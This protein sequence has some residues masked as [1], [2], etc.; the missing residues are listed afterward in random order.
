MQH[1]ITLV[2]AYF[3][4]GSSS[5]QVRPM[6]YYFSVAARLLPELPLPMVIYCCPSIVQ[7]VTKLRPGPMSKQTEYRVMPLEALPLYK[8]REKIEQNRQIYW[9]TKDG[10]NT[11]EVHIVVCSKPWFVQQVMES[12]PFQTS[13]FAWMDFGLAHT[14][15][16]HSPCNPGLVMER[17]EVQHVPAKCRVMAVNAIPRSLLERVSNKDA[18][19]EYY[20][21][22]RFSYAGSFW[23]CGKDYGLKFCRLVI[24]VVEEHIQ[25]GYGHAEEMC[26]AI[27]IHRHPEWFSVYCGDF[28]DLLTN[29]VAPVTNPSH[30]AFVQQRFKAC[31]ES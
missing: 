30:V 17:L 24:Q 20:E 4:L 28:N 9:P 16:Q 1:D 14:A 19:Q 25:Q 11:A 23:T 18:L 26:M 31:N 13:R 15:F 22:Y 5:N 27:V 10:R 3:P 7:E 12:N 2:T 21:R 6:S 29:Y 8:Y